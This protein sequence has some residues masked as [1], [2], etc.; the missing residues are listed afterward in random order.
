[1]QRLL[2]AGVMTADGLA[3]MTDAEV[4]QR[5]FE[6]PV[7]REEANRLWYRPQAIGVRRLEGDDVPPG[8]HVVQVDRLYLAMPLVDGEVV[9]RISQRAAAM[10]AEAWQL[11]GTYAVSWRQ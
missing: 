9:T 1:V 11:R 6:A 2:D 10:L 7:T 4:E 3:S 5:L 8:A